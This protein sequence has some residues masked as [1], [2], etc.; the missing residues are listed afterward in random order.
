MNSK[1]MINSDS[2]LS[3]STSFISLK[4]SESWKTDQAVNM[5]LHWDSRG[6]DSDTPIEIRVFKLS[7]ENVTLCN[8]SSSLRKGSNYLS[9]VLVLVLQRHPLLLFNLLF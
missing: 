3:N 9:L 5:Y 2:Q 4:S 8:V 1:K 7:E 6:Y